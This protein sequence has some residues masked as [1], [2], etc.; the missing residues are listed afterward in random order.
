MLGVEQGQIVQKLGVV[1]FFH[2]NFII[3][4]P[5]LSFILQ[6]KLAPN[7]GKV[8][9]TSRGGLGLCR[10]IASKIFGRVIFNTRSA[11]RS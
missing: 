6:K 9:H 1:S 11:F 10:K 8:L 5:L 3:R 7:K 4:K 2:F